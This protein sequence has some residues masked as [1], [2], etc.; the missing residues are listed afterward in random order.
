VHEE[1]DDPGRERGW[2]VLAGLG[3]LRQR[4]RPDDEDRREEYES[5]CKPAGR[6]AERI[7]EAE[8]EVG[9]EDDQRN[10]NASDCP[11]R[12]VAGMVRDETQE[13][14]QPERAECDGRPPARA[15][16]ASQP[17]GERDRSERDERGKIEI[18]KG[19]NRV[20]QGRIP[21]GDNGRTVRAP[22]VVVYGRLD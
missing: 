5:A 2:A 18:S 17:E 20:V 14:E 16:A 11:L 6:R 22:P 8:Q 21:R 4:E 15:I 12:D 13:L 7:R 10:R 3:D 1:D 19:L 9:K